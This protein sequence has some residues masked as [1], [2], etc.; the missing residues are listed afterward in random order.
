[1]FK[2]LT[3]LLFL[4]IYPWVSMHSEEPFQLRGRRVAPLQQQL[5]LQQR[6]RTALLNFLIKT[7]GYKNYLEIGVSDGANFAK[8]AAARKVGVD[9]S[10]NSAATHKMTSDEFFTKNQETFDLIF[11]DGLHLCEQV[12]RDIDHALD[13]L[14]PGGRIVMHDCLPTLMVH[15]NRKRDP[16]ITEWTG[17]VWKA[18]AYVRMH[19][20]DVH[21]CVINM[22]WGCGVITPGKGQ[23]VFPPTSIENLDWD[24]YVRNRKELLKI[25]SLESWLTNPHS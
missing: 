13:C 12:L 21:F 11:I 6:S 24:F 5:L 20:D 1:M 8:I 14:S 9:P 19:Y 3:A 16:Q 17:D 7:Q 2:Q 23:K 15:Q 10:L 18:A 25:V 22:D 4:V